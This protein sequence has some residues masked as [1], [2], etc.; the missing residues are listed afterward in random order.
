MKD[1][2]YELPSK[3]KMISNTYVSVDGIRLVM[4][5]C[6]LTTGRIDAICDFLKI[7][8]KTTYKNNVNILTRLYPNIARSHRNLTTPFR[9]DVLRFDEYDFAVLIWIKEEYDEKIPSIETIIKGLDE[10]SNYY[11]NYILWNPYDEHIDVIVEKI[12]RI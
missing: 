3:F 11:K 9:L 6:F 4:K 1:Y 2:F 7:D 12:D 8:D 10:Y 5:Q